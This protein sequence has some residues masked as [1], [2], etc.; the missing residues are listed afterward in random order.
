MRKVLNLTIHRLTDEQEAAGVVPLPPEWFEDLESQ[1]LTEDL[2]SPEDIEEKARRIV[3]LADDYCADAGME[4]LVMVGGA[5]WLMPTLEKYL[6]A[7]RFRV[8]YA[9][10]KRRSKEVTDPKTGVVYK[11]GSFQ[12]LGF[13][14]S[15]A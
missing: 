4:R 1:V 6:R 7:A 2:P 11:A 15:P 12:H 3:R 10:S 8:F 14:E 13:V 9:F 5:P